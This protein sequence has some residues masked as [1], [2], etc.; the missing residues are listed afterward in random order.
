MSFLITMLNPNKFFLPVFFLF[1]LAPF[2]VAHTGDDEGLHH[3]EGNAPLQFPTWTYYAEI[4]EHLLSFLVAL[5]IAL[6]IRLK[7][8]ESQKHAMGALRFAFFGFMVIATGEFLTTLHHFLIY[9]FG[10]YDSIANHFLF[11]AGLVLLAF[12]F[13]SSR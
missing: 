8:Y 7:L 13:Y 11:L 2:I 6:F 5:G 1:F 3:P 12:S 9:P 10:I 4:F